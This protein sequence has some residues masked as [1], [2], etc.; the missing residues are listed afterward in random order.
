MTVWTGS[1]AALPIARSGSLPWSP[2]LADPAARLASGL[3]AAAPEALAAAVAGEARRRL[4]ATLAGIAAY[5]RHPYRRTLRDPPVVWRDGATRLLDYGARR[6]GRDAAAPALFVPSLVNRYYILDLSRRR[7]LMRYLA[8]EGVRPLLLDWGRPGKAEREFGLTDYITRRLEP[9]L[10]AAVV[11]HGGPVTVVGYCMGGLL[12]LALAL[13][14]PRQVR[15]LALLATPWDFHAA[16]DAHARLLGAL[17]APLSGLIAALGELPVDALQAM[18]TW[19]DPSMVAGKFRAFAGRDME[20]PSAADFVAL[21][22]WLNDGVALTAGVARDCLFGWYGENRPARG[23]WR[24]AGAA[25]TPQALRV[26]ALVALPGR[27]RIVPPASAAALADAL[28][29][30]E[31]LTPPAGHIGMI[32]GGTARKT[33]WRPLAA[34]LRSA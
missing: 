22:D 34:W 25:V 31:R 23:A 6:K 20:S 9:A 1:L 7:G 16:E 32:V 15:A 5:R 26:P 18:F 28:P 21:E 4:G 14:R 8:G 24:V 29:S 3:A 27:D 12:A 33:L 13:R 10:D 30:A 2:A 19:S 11:A 17:D